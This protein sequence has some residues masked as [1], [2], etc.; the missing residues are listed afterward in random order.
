MVTLAGILLIVTVTDLALHNPMY[1][2]LK[3][4]SLLDIYCTSVTTAKMMANLLSEDESI[5][6]IRCAVQMSLFLVVGVVGCLCTLLAVMMYNG[7]VTISSPLTYVIIMNR[8]R[9]WAEFVALSWLGSV[10]LQLRQVCLV[11]FLSFSGS[12]EKD[13]LF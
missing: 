1:F 2:F 11:F 5:Y 3:N 8:R 6:F 12:N 13:H 7:Y 10:L 9:V 4:L